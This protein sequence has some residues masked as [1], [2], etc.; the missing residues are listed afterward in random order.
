MVT[1][2][3]VEAGDV[4]G[5]DSGRHRAGRHGR[6]PGRQMAGEYVE[7]TSMAH[8]IDT[9]SLEV[10]DSVLVDTRPR[11]ARFTPDGSKVWVSSEV[12]GTVAVIDVAT[13]KIL[14]KIEFAVQGLRKENIQ[15]VGIS[16]T[17]DGNTRLR[18]LGTGP[19]ASPSS[20]PRSFEVKKYLLVASGSGQQRAGPR[21]PSCS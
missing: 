11:F 18:P 16:I 1:V 21:I 7:T 6:Q 14:H 20:I 2:L 19:T 4:S 13:R 5:R 15:P 17:P 9:S 8:F 12:G 10:V 3:D